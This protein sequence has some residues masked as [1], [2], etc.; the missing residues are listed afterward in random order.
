MNVR[1]WH[2]IRQRLVLA[3][4]II[5]LLAG[6]LQLWVAGGQIERATLDFFQRDLENDVYL[7]RDRFVLSGTGDGEEDN[8]NASTQRLQLAELQQ[9]IGHDYAILNIDGSLEAASL[10][11]YGDFRQRSLSPEVNEAYAQGH[12]SDVRVGS[13]KQ[14]RLYVAVPFYHD[15]EAS[16][17][18]V[19]SQP[20]QPIY[21]DIQARWLRLAAA[22][23]PVLLLAL[24]IGAWLGTNIA[25]PIKL[26]HQTA[27]TVAEGDLS[28]RVNLPN[29]DEIGALG[30]AFNH[31]ADQLDQLLKTQRAFI[32][33][34]AHELRTPLMTMQ[35]RLEALQGGKLGDEQRQTYLQ[36]ARQELR[37]MAH[38]VT[39]LLVLARLDERRHQADTTAYD[40]AA[41]LADLT[42]EWRRNA[43]N[44]GLQFS[45]QGLETLPDVLIPAQDLRMVL[46]NLFSN[47][48]KYTPQGGAVCVSTR[49]DAQQAY[50]SIEDTGIGFNAKQAEL[51]FTRFYRSEEARGQGIE[52]NGLGLSIAQA[53]IERS[54]GTLKAHSDGIGQG[55]RF[56]ICLPRAPMQ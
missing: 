55:A 30:E 2:S 17:A 26:L 5:T 25:R 46:D 13:D 27:L 50:L 34:A 8:G 28:A 24:G 15:E 39:S 51:I 56:E 6:A 22:S 53:I 31:M 7:A 44:N 40:A 38:L 9:S 36:E 32:S 21:A 49:A 37:H 47:A 12:G 48:L 3:F 4:A 20:L 35:L 23:V 14:E 42:R 41:L 33:N 11:L 43:Q 19:L 52:G 54:H 16:G 1:G 10:A 29:H 18:L 45:V